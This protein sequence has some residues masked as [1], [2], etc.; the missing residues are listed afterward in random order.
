MRNYRLLSATA[1][2]GLP[3]GASAISFLPAEMR[4]HLDFFLSLRHIVQLTDQH[5]VAV[6]EN[7]DLDQ[8]RTA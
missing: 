2:K 4:L 6:R 1:P 7:A 8:Q 5:V 3:G